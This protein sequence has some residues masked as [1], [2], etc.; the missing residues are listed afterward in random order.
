MSQMHTA[1]RGAGFVLILARP[2]PLHNS[3]SRRGRSCQSLL[4]ISFTNYVG[5]PTRQSAV[6]EAI[7]G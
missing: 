1:D 4:R 2:P 6:M 5:P 3:L 7:N